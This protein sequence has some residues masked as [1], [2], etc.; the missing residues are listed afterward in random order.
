MVRRI[1]AK[2]AFAGE[3]TMQTWNS[4]PGSV[5]F[6]GVNPGRHEAG[7]DCPAATVTMS[8]FFTLP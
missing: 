4:N 5:L 3:R 6:Q 8:M 2:E 7:F 1:A